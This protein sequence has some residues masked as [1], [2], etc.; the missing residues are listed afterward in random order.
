MI[1][2]LGIEEILLEAV[3]RD[4]IDKICAAVVSA[5]V[6][7]RD[8]DERFL[9]RNFDIISSLKVVPFDVVD[10]ND[11]DVDGA[12]DVDAVEGPGLSCFSVGIIAVG[13]RLAAARTTRLLSS[14]VHSKKESD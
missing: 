10:D 3:N 9:P 4:A 12:V 7:E 2:V 1:G 5:S 6:Q 13:R 14:G 11:V 8:A